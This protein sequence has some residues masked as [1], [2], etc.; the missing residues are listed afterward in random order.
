MDRN[1]LFLLHTVDFVDNFGISLLSAVA[2]QN[3]WRT[4]L[5]IFDRRTIHE[6]FRKFPPKL[7]CYSVMSS[8]ADV[9]LGINAYLKSHY[10]FIS[11][12]GG[13]HPTFFPEVIEREGLDYICRGEGELAFAEFLDRLAKNEDC[14]AIAN[15]GTKKAVNPLRPLIE[16]IDTIPLPDRGIM[17]EATE[18]RYS[19]LKTLMT[20]RGCPFACSYCYNNALKEEYRNLGTY[21]RMHSVGRVI[22]E[23]CEMKAAY[24]LAF[25]KFEDDLFAYKKSWLAEFAQAYKKEVKLPF[26]CLQRIDLCDEERFRIL[27]DA[28][29]VSISLSIDSGSKRIRNDILHRQMQLEN[30]EIKK[31]IHQAK[32]AGLNVMTSTILGV[33][34]A[35]F[36]DEMAGLQLN[37]ESGVD[38]AGAP[39]LL[40]FPRTGIWKYCQEH[41]YLSDN[42]LESYGSIQKESSLKCF[43]KREKEVQWNL[44]TFYPAI[45][46]FAWLRGPLL[47]LATRGKP[48]ALFAALHVFIKG[49]LMSR[50]IYR[51]SG[52]WG[53]KVKFLFKA[54]K[55]EVGRMLGKSVSA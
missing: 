40:P 26:N 41:G 54:L 12:M 4:Q 55:I 29:C 53:A 38:F 47:R 13:P 35:T 9:Y 24:P 34:T 1:I 19:P 50:Y 10:D 20:S 31:R 46:K 3:G 39:I 45:V 33:P 7:V 23:I 5:A 17:F 30:E 11:V 52:N 16:D 48:R 28:G 36:E 8:D 14:S 2:K 25:I 32:A 15:F 42:P 21:V 44:S 37:I 22:A 6:V 49:Y 27:K 43:T 18:L 51:F